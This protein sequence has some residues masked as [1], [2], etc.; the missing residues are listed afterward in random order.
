M[1]KSI[2]KTGTN[3]KCLEC[4]HIWNYQDDACPNCGGIFKDTH[5]DLRIPMKTLTA[6]ETNTIEDL[7]TAELK[8]T[9]GFKRRIIELFSISNIEDECSLSDVL[10]RLQYIMDGYA[11][12]ISK[13]P[14][15]NIEER[16]REFA[17]KVLKTNYDN[18]ILNSTEILSI[19]GTSFIEYWTEHGENDRKMR[20]EKQASFD[21]KRRLLTWKNNNFNNAK[22]TYTDKLKEYLNR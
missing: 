16:R 21:I 15:N 13:E 6:K 20:F 14:G 2:E 10:Y 12:Y 17:D 5:H 18:N 7:E 19:N 9:G 22:P 8:S 3:Y 1:S 11:Q 4:N